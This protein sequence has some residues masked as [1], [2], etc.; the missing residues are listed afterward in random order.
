MQ[1]LDNS[2][3]IEISQRYIC[4]NSY[5]TLPVLLCCSDVLLTL[6]FTQLHTSVLH[7]AFLSVGLSLIPANSLSR[8]LITIN[9]IPFNTG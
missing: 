2:A 9:N 6:P 5:R 8:L 4:L 1:F 7:W 3:T